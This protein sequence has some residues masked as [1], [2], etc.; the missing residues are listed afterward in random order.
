MSTKLFYAYKLPKMNLKT[1]FEKVEQVKSAISLKQQELY[2]EEFLMRCLSVLDFKTLNPEAVAH[3]SHSYHQDNSTMKVAELVSYWMEAE[4]KLHKQADKMNMFYFHVHF[5]FRKN[6]IYAITRCLN[7][8]NFDPDFVRITGAE[9]YE[10]Y[11]HTDQPEDITRAQWKKREKEW[12]EVFGNHAWDSADAKN[13]V[14]VHINFPIQR[15]RYATAENPLIP[16][17]K[18]ILSLNR[19][20]EE[21]ENQLIQEKFPIIPDW[22]EIWAYMRSDEFIE[23]RKT[24]CEELMTKLICNPQEF[25]FKEQEITCV[26]NRPTGTSKVLDINSKLDII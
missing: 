11:N 10:Y 15:Q 2:Q 7:H 18:L 26:K 1:F 23:K 19:T 24:R 12:D 22:S 9:L 6:R 14:K 4:D 13:S 21:A 20:R 8:D 17:S 16:P 5:L 25:K 3:F